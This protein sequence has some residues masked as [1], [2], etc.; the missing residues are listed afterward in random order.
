[1]VAKI[2]VH[3]KLK[4]IPGVRVTAAQALAGQPMPDPGRSN[5]DSAKIAV[6]KATRRIGP[7]RS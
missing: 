2:A 1:M 4:P 5:P 7:H 3:N 6:D